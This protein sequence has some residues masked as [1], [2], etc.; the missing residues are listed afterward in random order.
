MSAYIRGSNCISVLVLC[1]CVLHV[2]RKIIDPEVTFHLKNGVSLPLP[3]VS[4]L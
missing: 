4:S 3:T 2:V 1:K